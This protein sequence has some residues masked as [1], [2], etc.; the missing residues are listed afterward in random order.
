M[1]G[2]IIGDVVGSVYEFQP[3]KTKNFELFPEKATFT[4][5][6]VMTITVARALMS[7]KNCGGSFRE[8][9]IEQMQ[10]LGNKYPYAGYGGM[11]SDWLHN[12]DPEPYNS[13]GNGSAMRVSPVGLYANSIEEALDLAKQSSEVTHNH[14]EGIKGAQATA[15]AVFLAKTGESRHFIRDYINHYFYPIDFTLNEI[16]DAY[17]FDVTCQGS[18]PPAIVAFLESTSFEDA[19]RNAI[20]LGGD[21]DPLAAITGS[22]AWP[23]YLV[24]NRLELPD[25]MH[26]MGFM[27]MRRIPNEFHATDAEFNY[28]I[29]PYKKMREHFEVY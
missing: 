26:K 5:D 14:P 12:P 3:I 24:Q 7:Y 27:T 19:I 11:F 6:T 28:H 4:D 18:V 21:S 1:Y 2:A 9:L 16:R 17:S 29:D 22:I 20:S 10:Y 8:I 25:D 13:Y 15:A 23:Y